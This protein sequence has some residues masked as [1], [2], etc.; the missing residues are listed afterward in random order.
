[1]L[2][3]GLKYEY[4]DVDIHHLL[5]HTSP[6]LVDGFEW[7]STELVIEAVMS[8]VLYRQWYCVQVILF[9]CDV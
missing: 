4:Q 5:D 7:L 3:D 1:M 9:L 2:A 6:V 8:P